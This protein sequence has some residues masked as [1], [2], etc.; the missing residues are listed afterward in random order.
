[1]KVLDQKLPKGVQPTTTSSHE[2]IAGALPGTN[3]V[4]RLTSSLKK[5]EGISTRIAWP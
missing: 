5:A 1:M 2:A 3:I 4:F